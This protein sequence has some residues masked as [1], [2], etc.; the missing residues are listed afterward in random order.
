MLPAIVTSWTSAGSIRFRPQLVDQVVDRLHGEALQ[1]LQPAPALGVDDAADHVVPAG[2]LPVVGARAVDHAT[3]LE[4]D[5]IRDD[6][7][8]PQVDG[9]PHAT[10]SEGAR[11]DAQDTWWQVRAV[12][13]VAHLEGD[14]DP[15]VGHPQVASEA[16]QQGQ[17]GAHVPDAV[18]LGQGAAQPVEVTR[19]VG[20]RGRLD[21]DV[22][23]AHRRILTPVA[24]HRQPF[25]LGDGV[26]VR[27]H[28]LG[29]LRRHGDRDGLAHERPAGEGGA[30]RDLG[31]RQAAVI[32]ALDAR[33]GDAHP[34]APAAPLPAAGRGDLDSGDRRR[35]EQRRA[36]RHLGRP[37]A[38]QE[39]DDDRG[40]RAAAGR[41]PTGRCE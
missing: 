34:A 40:G 38:G 27:S 20:E 17:F 39:G 8:G 23:G 12:D 28:L 37:A 14:V 7:R 4:V 26:A 5:E 30:G 31:W 3:G 22:E 29:A 18:L 21:G 32:D 2:D 10:L 15:P 13:P 36:G 19:V 1:A 35:V 41:G 25:G 6:R 33:A 9:E 16:A 11:V 24:A